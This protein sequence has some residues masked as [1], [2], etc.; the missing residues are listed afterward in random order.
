MLTYAASSTDDE[1]DKRWQGVWMCVGGGGTLKALLRLYEGA[2]EALLRL[3]SGA[4]KALNGRRLQGALKAL[5]RLYSGAIKGL[6]RR[7]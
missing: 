1:E 5:F 2:V 4:I 7:Y 6:F 3:Y